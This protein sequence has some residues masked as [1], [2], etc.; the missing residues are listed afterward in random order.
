MQRARIGIGQLRKQFEHALAQCQRRAVEQT[1][2]AADAALGGRAPLPALPVIV[3]V[4]AGRGRD[5]ARAT[6]AAS[7]G[8]SS[9]RRQRE[10]MVG[11]SR[12]GAWLTSSS[13][14]RGGGSSSTFSSALA[15]SR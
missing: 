5:R 11:N 6:S 9:S 3:G 7:S 1:K 13:S 14:V 10:R 12:P 8:R 15:P 2:R 4:A